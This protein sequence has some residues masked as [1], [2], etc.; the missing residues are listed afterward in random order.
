[1]KSP[2]DAGIDDLEK[3]IEIET[4]QLAAKRL[5]LDILISMRNK[6]SGIDQGDA[7]R[8]NLMDK[9]LERK[10]EEPKERSGDLVRRA[11]E[12]FAGKVF[13]VRD[14]EHEMQVAGTMF[15]GSQPRSRILFKSPRSS[16]SGFAPVAVLKS[17]TPLPELSITARRSPFGLSRSFSKL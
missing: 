10:G 3:E 13:T 11:V 9:S 8:R 6:Y 14:I 12:Q 1:M 4:S 7:T 2:F 5:A 17:S 15:V 16:A